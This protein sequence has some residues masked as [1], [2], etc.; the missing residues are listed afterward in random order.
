MNPGAIFDLSAR[1]KFRLTGADRLRYLNGQVSNDVRKASETS[2]VHACVLNAKGKIN[3]DIFVMVDGD[4][5]LVDAETETREALPAR[6][7]RYIIAD[8]VQIE[9][10]TEKFALLHVLGEADLLRVRVASSTRY[11]R[12]GTDIWLPIAERER[13]LNAREVIDQA[14]AER[15]RIE[16]GIPR[17]GR[18]LTE[19]IIPPEANLEASAIDYT[20][21][22]YIGQ[23][24]ISRMKMSGQ[25]NKRLCGLVSLDGAALETEMRLTSDD[26]KEAGWVTSVTRS[27]EREIA[28]AFV[29]R[30]W[31]EIG[32]ELAAGPE[33]L[34]VRVVALPFAKP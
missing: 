30:G 32:T 7:E 22:C 17:W 13:A 28:L 15:F 24:V 21:G 12:P 29:K 26:G 31:N 5:F 23:E 19:E 14:A 33:A 11:G 25:T 6:F 10:V 3:A 8:D 2:A 20:K 1:A 18:E 16:E 4:S 9:D 34:R 27:S